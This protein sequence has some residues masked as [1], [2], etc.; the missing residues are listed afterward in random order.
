M[1]DDIST[2]HQKRTKTVESRP[3]IIVPTYNERENLPRLLD[4]IHVVVPH[5]EVLIVDDGSPDGTG[6]LADERAAVDAWVHVMHRE[7]K[8][9]L[10]TAYLAGFAWAL[11]RDYTHIF[12]MDADFSHDPDALPRFLEAAQDAD[13]VLGSR[14]VSGGGI[15][16]WPLRRLMISKFGSLYARSI[17]NV[18]IRDLT[19]GFKCFH[20]RVLQALELD[21]VDA[22]G[23]G[24]QIELTF[25]ALRQGF[26]V[27]EI[28][29][30]FTDRI[31]GKSKMSTG[32]FSEAALLVWKL[33]LGLA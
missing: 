14:W 21:K 8:L 7:G 32:I 30:T 3:L 27:V 6:E 25:R 18:P 17:L 13:L 24:F 16:G 20:R 22:V 12:E 19:G 1:L 11:E 2:S 9:G 10:G 4:R 33:R 5:A 23:Y 26:K 29:I 31:A 28:P 15:V